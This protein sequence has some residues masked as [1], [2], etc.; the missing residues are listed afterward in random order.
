MSF[1]VAARPRSARCY[2]AAYTPCL[3]VYAD[4]PAATKHAKRRLHAAR[5]AAACQA[6]AQRRARARRSALDFSI[7]ITPP[8]LFHYYWFTFSR[9]YCFSSP[10]F[11]SPLMITDTPAD[12]CFI[13]SSSL[14]HFHIFAFHCRH[15]AIIFFLSRHYFIFTP[16]F[17]PF[18][19]RCREARFMRAAGAHGQAR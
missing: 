12:F 2:S 5:G 17:S 4:T 1:G 6:H 18:D 10:F 15:F 16:L 13:I 8:R 11:F 19:A 14:R 9:R 7:I 3:I